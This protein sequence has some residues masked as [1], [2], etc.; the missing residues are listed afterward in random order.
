MYLDGKI[1]GYYNVFMCSMRMQHERICMTWN[2]YLAWLLMA[3]ALYQV[4][5]CLYTTMILTHGEGK[6]WCNI[7]REIDAH[8]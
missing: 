3:L 5:W 1:Q 6:N 7:D 8:Y 4:T 2:L